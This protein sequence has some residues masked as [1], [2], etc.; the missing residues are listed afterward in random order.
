MWTA[1]IDETLSGLELLHDIEAEETRSSATANGTSED[2]D[3]SL[4]KEFDV[5]LSNI[6]TGLSGTRLN[7]M[8]ELDTIR[9]QVAQL[10]RDLQNKDRR[11]KELVRQ[12]DE[13]SKALADAN[14]SKK[15][16]R[17]RSILPRPLQQQSLPRQNDGTLAPVQHLRNKH[18]Q[19]W[20]LQ[21]RSCSHQRRSSHLKCRGRLLQH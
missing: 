15:K 19:R 21:H 7:E 8:A 3:L 12:T 13:Q 2:V 10:Q 20:M 14:Q 4:E 11:I 16:H 18:Q 6:P 1:S 9:E 5:S 17:C